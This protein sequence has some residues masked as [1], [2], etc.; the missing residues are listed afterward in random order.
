MICAAL[1][2]LACGASQPSAY[3]VTGEVVEIREDGQ[4]VIAHDPIEGFM[5][6]MTMPF[7]VAEPDELRGI[8]PGDRIAGTL[9]LEGGTRLRQLRVTQPAPAPAPVEGPPELAPGEAVPVGAI[10]PRTPVVLARGSP[11]TVGQG[12]RGRFAV[13]FVYTRCPIPEYC[14]LVVS[15]FQALQ[16]QLPAHARLLAITLDP[17]HDTRSVLRDFAEASGAQPGRWDFGRVPGEVLF[18]L[19]EKAGLQT[20]GKGLGITHDLVLLILDEQGRLVQR[21]TDMDWEL[22]EVVALLEGA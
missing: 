8:G 11:V 15:R 21:Y 10:F 14:P 13:T 9:T 6:A 16:A 2:W 22:Q 3:P 4:I 20:H 7:T 19:A 12:Q 5:E 1:L 18:G 17:E